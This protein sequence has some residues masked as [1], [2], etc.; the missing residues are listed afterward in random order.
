MAGALVQCKLGMLL[1]MPSFSQVRSLASYLGQVTFVRI[2]SYLYGLLCLWWEMEVEVRSRRK[3]KD[4][5][6]SNRTE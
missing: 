2:S 4:I 6:G 1:A 3:G 5:R